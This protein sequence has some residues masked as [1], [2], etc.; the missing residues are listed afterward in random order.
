MEPWGYKDFNIELE[1]ATTLGRKLGWDK[2]L[3]RRILIERTKFG[4]IFE[5]YRY[6][7]RASVAVKFK[8][9]SGYD[10]W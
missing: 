10:Y 1:I 5:N 7:T 2:K 4:K 3:R 9:W 6:R 8:R